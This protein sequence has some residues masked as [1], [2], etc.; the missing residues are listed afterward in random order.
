MYVRAS[1]WRHVVYLVKSCTCQP[2]LLEYNLILP[3][4]TT[5]SCGIHATTD[6]ASWGVLYSHIYLFEKYLTY[7]PEYP[8]MIEDVWT[9]VEENSW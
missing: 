3:E 5:L 7:S 2:C 9:T 8:A 6:E 4:K 1:A